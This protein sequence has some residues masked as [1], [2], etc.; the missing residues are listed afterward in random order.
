M[1]GVGRRGFAAATRAYMLAAPVGRPMGPQPQYNRR[2]SAPNILELD[3]AA[4]C[5]L[6][7]C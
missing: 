4:R 7:L 2:P 5:T 6:F 3:T 1:A